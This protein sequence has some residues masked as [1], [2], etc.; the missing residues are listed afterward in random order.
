LASSWLPLPKASEAVVKV[1]GYWGLGQSSQ[2]VSRNPPLPTPGS[3]E[4]DYCWPVQRI[5]VSAGSLVNLWE[6]LFSL[7]WELFTRVQAEEGSR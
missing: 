3:L 5:P 2:R 7:Q 6:S 1:A 4:A